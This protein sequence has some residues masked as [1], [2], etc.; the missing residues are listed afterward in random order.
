MRNRKEI[1]ELMSVARTGME[2]SCAKLIANKKVDLTLGVE[3]ASKSV[4][5]FITDAIAV[6]EGVSADLKG[7][8][9]PKFLNAWTY[10]GEEKIDYVNFTVKSKL[11]VQIPV[12][13]KA[14]IYADEDFEN[15]ICKLLI[16]T[17][18]EIFLIDLASENIADFVTGVG[19]IIADK[20]FDL[21]FDINFTL[22]DTA[23]VS[24]SNDAITLGVSC[25]NALDISRLPIFNE[26]EEGDATSYVTYL[27]EKAKDTFVEELKTVQ[28]P[29]QLLKANIRLFEDI[30]SLKTKKRAD[31]ILR[32]VY[33]K[34]AKHLAT[35]KPSVG[36][37]AEKVM[38]GDEEVEI[39]A[40][41]QKTDSTKEVVLN[42]FNKKTLETVDFDVLALA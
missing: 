16:D 37:V 11:N 3:E 33:H 41:V 23:I 40:L 10:A 32:D 12:K 24:I 17:V 35:K 9:L 1:V 15:Q 20:E 39:F 25:E 5:K 21:P 19:T 31:S 6:V 36:Y 26:P 18:L 2:A 29:I 7:A 13:N 22:S 8:S 42:P 4:G 34:Q 14:K 38:I 27:A 28:T 30:T